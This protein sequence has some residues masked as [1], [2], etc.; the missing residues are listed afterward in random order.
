MLLSVACSS[1]PPL[2]ATLKLL[3][4][5]N[6]N[7]LK[8]SWQAKNSCLHHQV[9]LPICHTRSKRLPLIT[10]PRGSQHIV[11][12]FVV[13]N[14]IPFLCMLAFLFLYAHVS[15]TRILAAPRGL[16][17]LPHLIPICGS[18]KQSTSQRIK[19]DVCFSI[20]LLE[21]SNPLGSWFMNSDL[22]HDNS[23]SWRGPSQE[24]NPK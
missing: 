15:F 17:L 2:S 16:Q 13:R 10:C 5:L 8:K 18:P 7:I 4:V 23:Y 21:H 24:F 6:Q 22:S 9:A 19:K 12:R 11:G 3:S 14:V 20:S 1:P